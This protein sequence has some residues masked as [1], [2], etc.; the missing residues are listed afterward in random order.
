V[1]IGAMIFLSIKEIA[2]KTNPVA[3]LIGCLLGSVIG[4][5]VGTWISV[6]ILKG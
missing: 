4:S 5:I 1:I 6:I 3:K 2:D